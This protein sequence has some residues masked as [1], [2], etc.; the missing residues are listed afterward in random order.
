SRKKDEQRRQRMPIEGAL[1]MEFAIAPRVRA[2]LERLGLVKVRYAGLEDELASD[3]FQRLCADFQLLP[4]D[5]AYSVLVLLDEVRQR[6]ALTPR[7]LKAR[8]FGGSKLARDYGI[9]VNRH[10]GIPVA[11]LPPGQKSSRGGSYKLV[12]VWNMKG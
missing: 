5:A 11:F 3:A 10:V 7:A 1:L 6:M 12:S 8:L 9:A 2:G 4:H